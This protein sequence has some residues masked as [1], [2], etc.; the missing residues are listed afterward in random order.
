MLLKQNFRPEFLN[1]LDEIVFYKPLEK[2][3][4]NKIVDLILKDI[5]KRLEDKR[6]KVELT[7]SA[8]E[9]VIEHGY[10]VNY[11]A[12][13]LKRYIQDSI[14]TLLAKAIIADQVVMDSNVVVDVKN[15]ELELSNI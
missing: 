14:E 9:F 7:D 5:C 13:P 4:I 12:R 6:I 3:Q 10:D 1:R 11:G 2:E 8:K 15:D